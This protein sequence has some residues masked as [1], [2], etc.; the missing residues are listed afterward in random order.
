[1][2]KIQV[3]IIIL[4]LIVI[5]G[6]SVLIGKEISKPSTKQNEVAKNTTIQTEKEPE[7]KEPEKE[8]EPDAKGLTE[9]DI[10]NMEEVDKTIESYMNTKEFREATLDEK[11]ELMTKKLNDL[12]ENGTDKR[13]ESL[14][15]KESISTQKN[16]YS[17]M[18]SFEYACGTLGGVTVQESKLTYSI[19]NELSLYNSRYKER[20]IYYDTLNQPDAPSIYTIAMGERPTGGYSIEV[21]SV[22]ID[23]NENVVVIVEENTEDM[24]TAVTEAFTYPVCQVTLS[25]SPKSIVIK[26]TSGEIFKNVN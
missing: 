19:N 22:T 7:K 17:T 23:D 16:T 4:L 11:V 21:K 2:R 20:G 13:K 12:A 26:N 3:V 25:H 10:V 14:I 8:E 15:K 9:D 6:L 18:I 5:V 24:R 1:M